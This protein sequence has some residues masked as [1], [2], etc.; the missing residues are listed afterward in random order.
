MNHGHEHY[1]MKHNHMKFGQN[2]ANQRRERDR[3]R[4]KQSCNGMDPIETSK[5]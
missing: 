3:E 1:F 5:K 4:E 2:F